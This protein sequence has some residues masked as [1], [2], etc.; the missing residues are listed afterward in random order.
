MHT[1]NWNNMYDEYEVNTKLSDLYLC[2]R[3]ITQ[4]C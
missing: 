3:E 2:R 4:V 1:V